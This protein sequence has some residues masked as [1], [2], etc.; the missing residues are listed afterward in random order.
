VEGGGRW[1]SQN[2]ATWEYSHLKGLI[3]KVAQAG[4]WAVWMGVLYRVDGNVDSRGGVS[5]HSA[6][7]LTGKLSKIITECRSA[8]AKER[9]ERARSVPVQKQKQEGREE[10]IKVVKKLWEWEWEEDKRSVTRL[11]LKFLC[12]TASRTP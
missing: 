5:Y 12:S 2:V 3:E 8:I 11:R 4:S 1:S 9:K 6:S 10:L 7:K